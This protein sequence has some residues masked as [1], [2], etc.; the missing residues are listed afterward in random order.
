V[1]NNNL[2]V[3]FLSHDPIIEQMAYGQSQQMA[4][5]QS[6]QMHTNNQFNYIEQNLERSLE[7]QIKDQMHDMY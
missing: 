7:Q 2:D 5:G 1:E 4:Y 6:Q 3:E